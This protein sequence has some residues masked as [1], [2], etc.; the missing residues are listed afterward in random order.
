MTLTP[1]NTI[2][3]VDRPRRGG[4]PRRV[5]GVARVVHLAGGL[6]LALFVYGPP[7]S[8]VALQ[9]WMQW[10][11]VPA[12]GATGIALWKQAALRRL[13]RRATDLLRPRT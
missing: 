8:T 5:R 11:V 13:I 2:P 9:P 12:L 7:T 4:G 1:S 10:V 3:T 6:A